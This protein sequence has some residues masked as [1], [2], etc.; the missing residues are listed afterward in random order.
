MSKR[1]SP[2]YLS[3]MSYRITSNALIHC[4][5]R[6]YHFRVTLTERTMLYF[7]SK[8][9]YASSSTP[10]QT[11]PRPYMRRDPPDVMPLRVPQDHN[12]LRNCQQWPETGSGVQVYTAE[13]TDHLCGM[14]GSDVRKGTPPL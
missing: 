13:Q 14:N 11:R 9:K 10:F 8:A 3:V 12:G 1:E 7:L 6:T 4:V 5:L 2:T